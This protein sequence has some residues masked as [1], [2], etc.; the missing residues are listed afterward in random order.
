[1]PQHCIVYS[2]PNRS[3]IVLATFAVLVFQANIFKSIV[4]PLKYFLEFD[5]KYKTYNFFKRSPKQFI[6]MMLAYLYVNHIF[7][8]KLKVDNGIEDMVILIPALYSPYGLIIA[9]FC[10]RHKLTFADM[11]HGDCT[12]N[13]FYSEQYIKK[14]HLFFGCTFKFYVRS[15][16]KFLHFA[17]LLPCCDIEVIYEP[18]PSPQ[19]LIS[20][21]D[22]IL[23]CLPY[24]SCELKYF[25][26]VLTELSSNVNSERITV[27]PHPRILDNKKIMNKLNILR[28][29]IDTSS[30]VDFRRTRYLRYFTF[31]SSI[32]FSIPATPKDIVV[33]RDIDETPPKYANYF[34]SI[35]EAARFGCIIEDPQNALDCIVKCLS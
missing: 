25:I 4:K 22:D 20:R 35:E 24:T 6:N 3:N 9:D 18:L 33:L 28:L 32:I 23:I 34:E 2:I 15:Q 21:H 29:S 19:T 7:Q 16:N 5:R 11:Q 13:L 27:R 10:V 17:N 1:M 14:L 30:M 8:H 31:Q 26:E 12:V